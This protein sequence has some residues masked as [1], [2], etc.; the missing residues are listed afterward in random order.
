MELIF[1]LKNNIEDIEF[2]DMK[3]LNVLV[4][5]FYINMFKLMKLFKLYLNFWYNCDIY[6]IMIFCFLFYLF[7]LFFVFVVLVILFD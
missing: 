2:W 7:V 4:W 6:L 1:I 3:L 5:L